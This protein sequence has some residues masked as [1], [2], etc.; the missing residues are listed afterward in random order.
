MRVHVRTNGKC[1]FIPVPLAIVKL[2]ILFVKAPFIIK[3]IS[4]EGRK[5]IDVI[6]FNELNKCIDVLRSYRGLKLVEVRDKKGT[7]VTITI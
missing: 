6:N 2:G 7:E 3:Y 1:F 4:P 5:Y